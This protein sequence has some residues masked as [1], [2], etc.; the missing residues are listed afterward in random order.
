MLGLLQTI[1]LLGEEWKQMMVKPVL[2]EKRDKLVV[3]HALKFATPIRE[4]G[5]WK[6]GN[7]IARKIHK[8][9]IENL[10]SQMLKISNMQRV[11]FELQSRHKPGIEIL[12]SQMLKINNMQRASEVVFKNS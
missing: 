5:N 11:L 9:D 2:G 3:F 8:P 12:K 7:R 6:H 4:L 1:A 10:E